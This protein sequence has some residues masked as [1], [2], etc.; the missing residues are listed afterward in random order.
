MIVVD[1][2]VSALMLAAR[3][4]HADVA[5]LLLG[6]G[7]DVYQTDANAESAIDYARKYPATQELLR[8]AAGRRS[9]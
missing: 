1:G 2:G 8:N 6:H 5:S 4:G 7:A 9:P 3:G